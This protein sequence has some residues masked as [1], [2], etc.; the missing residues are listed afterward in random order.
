MLQT[1]LMLVPVIERLWPI[2]KEVY[3]MVADPDRPEQ[4]E[5][6]L[7]LIIDRAKEEG[8]EIGHTE[9][10]LVRSAVHFVQSKKERHAAFLGR[11]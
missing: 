9:A 11:D 6:A 5:D 4:P 7:D 8:L 2:A 3:Q 1:I 10:E